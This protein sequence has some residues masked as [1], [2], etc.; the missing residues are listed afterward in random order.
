MTCECNALCGGLITLIIISLL[1]GFYFCIFESIFM[2]LNAKHDNEKK[3][4]KP[5]IKH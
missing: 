4:I 5:I 1:Y 3:N 2:Y